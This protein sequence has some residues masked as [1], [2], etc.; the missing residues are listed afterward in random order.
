M[1]RKQHQALTCI[2]TVTVLKT[3]KWHASVQQIWSLCKKT[4]NTTPNHHC[5]ATIYKFSQHY[6]GFASFNLAD[7]AKRCSH[8]LANLNLV[9]DQAF[10]PAYPLPLAVVHLATLMKESC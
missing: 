4:P 6:R 8:V 10:E 1:Q 5:P 2:T 7:I 3:P 9:Q